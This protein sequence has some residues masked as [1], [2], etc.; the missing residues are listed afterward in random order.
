MSIANIGITKTEHFQHLSRAPIIEAVLEIKARAEAPWEESEIREA[1]SKRLSDY[2]RILDRHQIQQKLHVH[3]NRAEHEVNDLGWNGL[4]FRTA[5]GKQIAR[6]D[7]NTFSF[8]RLKPYQRWEKFESEALRLYALHLSISRPSEAQRTG[9]RFINRIKLPPGQIRI[10]DYIVGGPHEPEGLSLGCSGFFHHDMILLPGSEFRGNV[11]RTIQAPETPQVGPTLI[12]DIDIYTVTPSDSSEAV[13]RRR[14]SDM[15]Y[16]K[17][18]I[19][20]G[21]ITPRTK[22]SL[23]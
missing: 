19:F 2:P 23:L 3:A 10:D 12:L 20:F 21:I 11:I 4:E 9:L 22:D 5:N 1:L 8:I 15:R 7:R 17:N 6:F 14:L 16:L 13:L 18:K